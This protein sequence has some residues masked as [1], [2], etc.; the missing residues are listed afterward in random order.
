MRRALVL[1]PYLGALWL[2]AACSSSPGEHDAGISPS[3]VGGG[4][5]DGAD[6]SAV[7]C[8]DDCLSRNEP[9]WPMPHPRS[10]P[11][12]NA[13]QYERVGKNV[14][15]RL[16]GL[17]WTSSSVGPLTHDEASNECDSLD[18]EQKQ[19]WRLPTLIE[20]ITLLDRT[21]V[22]TIDAGFF[23]DTPADYFWSSTPVQ[24]NDK[25][26]YSVYFGLGETGMG[27][28]GQRSG[29]VRCV[30]AGKRAG[31]PRF[32]VKDGWVWDRSTG[33]VWQQKPAAET[34]SR[35]GAVAY[36][37]QTEVAGARLPNEQELQTLVDT[38]RPPPRVDVVFSDTPSAKFWASSPPSA[39][40]FV[41][42]FLTGMAVIAPADDTHFVHC[43]AD[44]PE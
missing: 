13:A 9:N 7:P 43:V 32:S 25:L 2:S 23:P 10:L 36:C 26:A 33:L 29:Y 11:G 17:E 14:L 41:V 30:R 24:G 37:E 22:P 21:R 44:L 15:E 38:T 4:G 40:P 42:D 1:L 27:D 39:E 8:G 19:D 12:R 35:A 6:E 5:G 31:A 16:T 34:L 18:S 28:R 3:P 20:L